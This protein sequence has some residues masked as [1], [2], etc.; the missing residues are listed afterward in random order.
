MYTCTKSKGVLYYF[1]KGKRISKDKI[2]KDKLPTCKQMDT[3]KSSYSK[4]A[5]KPNKNQIL[6]VLSR[7]SMNEPTK[8][9]SFKYYLTN[10]NDANNKIKEIQNKVLK[11]N[12][13]AFNETNEENKKC[14]YK[15]GYKDPNYE[16]HSNIMGSFVPLENEDV[17]LIEKHSS[18]TFAYAVTRMNLSEDNEFIL[19]EH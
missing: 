1:L 16:E 6:L 17:F 15:I 19:F 2:P 12:I 14:P 13:D 7:I 10:K 5:E 18:F 3:A 8:E 11:K 4:K 9:I